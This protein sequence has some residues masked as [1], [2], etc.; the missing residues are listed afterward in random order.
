[1]DV[2]V[3]WSWQRPVQIG[4]MFSRLIQHSPPS[5]CRFFLQEEKKEEKI[6]MIKLIMV[7]NTP[8][9]FGIQDYVIWRYVSDRFIELIRC[10]SK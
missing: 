10:D 2:L 5:Q 9:H 1:M 8:H 4:S 3:L 6:S 7:F